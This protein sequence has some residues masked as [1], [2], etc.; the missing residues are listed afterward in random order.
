MNPKKHQIINAAYTLFINKGY[1]ASSIQDILNEAGVSKGTFYNYFTSK[2]ECLI[3][4][5]E[6]IGSEIRQKRMAAAVGKSVEDSE[7]LAE[8]LSLRIRLNREKNLFALY[9]SI[10]YS[11]DEILKNFAKVTYMA[12]LDW[13]ATR[14][15]DVFGKEAEPYALENAAIAHGSIQQLTNVWKLASSEELP[16][17]ELSAFVIRRLNTAIANQLASGD[18]FLPEL[19]MP[20]ESP[21]KV[22]SVEEL[23]RK[24][25]AI[26]KLLDE[27]ENSKQ[28]VAF[29][30]DELA[31]AEPRKALIES[32]LTTLAHADLHESELLI[33]LEQV[34]KQLPKL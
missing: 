7:V 13:I 28:L 22:L 26:T 16:T 11:K 19:E 32:V 6:S 29:L 25:D 31:A 2:A 23:S 8:Q 27:D 5:M 30:S 24:L 20:V 17:D 15:I 3:A 1:N 18:R 33:L 10:F 34:W 21:T 4:I 9:E 14:I 12:E